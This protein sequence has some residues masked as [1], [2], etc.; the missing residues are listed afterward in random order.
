MTLLS[1]P[2]ILRHLEAGSILIDPF[3]PAN[4][5]P[6]SYD[7]TLGRHCWREGSTH[8]YERRHPLYNPYSEEHV[9][10]LWVQDEAK[11]LDH[12]FSDDF[13]RRRLLYDTIHEDDMVILIEPGESILAH[14]QEFIGGCS[15]HIT[16]MMHARSSAGRNFLETVRC[17]GVGDVYYCNRWTLEIQNNSRYHI[18]PLV[19]GRRYAQMTF[20]EV[21][22]V[23]QD[24]VQKGGKYQTET[25]LEAMKAAWTPEAMLPRLYKDREVKEEN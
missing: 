8:I 16:T 15:P 17:A 22:P 5:G 1:K 18:I 4:L 12:F 7:V 13:I 9:W 11:P 24:Y 14:T 25:N 19:V 3:E 20:Y 10:A 21:E 23:E 6:N 2:A